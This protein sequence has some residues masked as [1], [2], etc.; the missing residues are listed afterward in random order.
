MRKTMVAVFCGFSALILGLAIGL[1]V[2][3]GLE[4][5]ALL[6]ESIE[7]QLKS[8]TSAAEE[9]IDSLGGGDAGFMGKYVTVDA[10]FEGGAAAAET[11]YETVDGKKTF[12]GS[13]QDFTDE[14]RL[15][16]AELRSLA[17]DVGADYIYTVM[18]IGNEYRLIFDTDEE[19]EEPFVLYKELGHVQ[20]DA[21]RGVDAAGVMN[22]TDEWGNWN[23]GARPLY[24][25]DDKLVGIVCADIEDVLYQE[26]I[27]RFRT[28]VI[29]LSVVLPIILVLFGVTLI[30]LLR[31]IKKMDGLKRVANYD[32]LTD[33][34]NRRYLLDQLQEMT[35]RKQTVPFALYFI[36]LDNFK[37]VNDNAGHDAGDELLKHIASYLEGVH[38]NS[39]VFR[40]EPGSINMTARVGGDEFIVIAPGIADEAA[41]TAFAQEI[42]DGFKTEYI[43]K[44]IDKYKVGL[45]IGVALYPGHIEN[46]HVLIKYA[47]MAMYHAKNAGKNRFRVYNDDMQADQIPD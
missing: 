43:D 35:A 6:R 18:Q 8:I 7:S 17:H 44:Y 10:F 4:S 12:I 30:L 36:D 14:M 29:T 39:K 26:S 41:A 38:T 24:D 5:R 3:S 20:L 21:F 46:F 11:L 31:Q 22:L 28:A 2:I 25:A 1:T 13:S 34:P 47:D 15:V 16:L 27:N 37:K 32:K 40:P 42:L 19:D 9:R 23:T 33:L 45:S